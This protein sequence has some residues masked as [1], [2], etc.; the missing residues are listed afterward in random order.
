VVVGGDPA[1]YLGQSD[2][3]V[4][5]LGAEKPVADFGVLWRPAR[6]PVE[7]V[8][9]GVEVARDLAMQ[10]VGQ[11]AVQ[12]VE[13]SELADGLVRGLRAGAMACGVDWVR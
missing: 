8:E 2:A 9:L 4:V 13:Q 11:L 1:E 12:V 6:T 7:A 10:G 3:L 5:Q